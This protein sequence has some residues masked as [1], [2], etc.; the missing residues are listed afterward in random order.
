MR[1]QV[2]T[3]SRGDMGSHKNR[4]AQFLLTVFADH[5]AVDNRCF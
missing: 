5:V 3:F 2:I 1:A 4:L